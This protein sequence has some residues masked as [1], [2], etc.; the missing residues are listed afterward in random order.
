MI[1]VTQSATQENNVKLSKVSLHVVNAIP[2]LFTHSI[3]FIQW[4]Q[5]RTKH[6]QVNDRPIFDSSVQQQTVVIQRPI[7]E[8]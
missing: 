1:F 3:I 4:I 6:G 5:I 2:L 7:S 8:P